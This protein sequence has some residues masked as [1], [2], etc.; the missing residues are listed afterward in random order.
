M[1][2]GEI[3]KRKQPEVYALLVSWI[4]VAEDPDR[5]MREIEKLMCH[6]AYRRERGAIRQ[7]RHT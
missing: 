3:L 2:I 4:Y 5:R 6:D 1:T 7:V